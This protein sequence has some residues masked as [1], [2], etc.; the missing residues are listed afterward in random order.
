MTGHGPTLLERIADG[1]GQVAKLATAVAPVIAAI[2]TEMKFNDITNTF[3]TYATATNSDLRCLTSN[4][5]QGT[6]EQQRIGQ[7]ILLKNMQ[8]RLAQSMSMLTNQATPVLGCHHRV[9]LLCWK[10]NATANV[11]TVTKILQAPSNIYSPVNKDYS[12]QFVILKDKHITF[13]ARLT[14]GTSTNGAGSQDFK[15]MK[16]YKPINW[17]LRWDATTS[18]TQ[19]HIWMLTMSTAPGATSAVNTTFYSRMNFTDN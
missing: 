2:N 9:M 8:V 16:W 4:V 14:P 17:H 13:N 18:V 10:D 12:D 5:F 11:P 3:S 19:N 6:G 7:S 15:S 1:A